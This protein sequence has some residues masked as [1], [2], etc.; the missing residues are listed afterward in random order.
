LLAAVGAALLAG[1]GHSRSAESEAL[2]PQDPGDLDGTQW[3]L[4]GTG[5][6]D[7]VPPSRTVTLNI[8]EGTAS[9]SGP[10]SQFRLPFSVDGDE[11]TTGPI[12]ATKVACAPRV[13]RAERRFFQALEKADTAEIV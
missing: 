11:L 13:R 10:C 3:V 2:V 4:V 1:C 5:G 9:G 12:A 7:A 6:T 8:A